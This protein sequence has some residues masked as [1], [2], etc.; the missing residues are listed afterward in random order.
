MNRRLLLAAASL[1]A[2]VALAVPTDVYVWPHLE[3]LPAIQTL[4]LLVVAHNAYRLLTLA[5][6]APALADAPSQRLARPAAYGEL[7][8]TGPAILATLA[9]MTEA[10]WAVPA[11]WVFNVVGAASLLHA[12]YCPSLRTLRITSSS[13]GTVFFIHTISALL[14]THA[15][16]FLVLLRG[17]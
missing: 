12:A 5:Y 11:V 8:V 10:G 1:G 4:T 7:A 14:V 3:A 2:V 9:L 17:L 15:L 6:L 16:I 13:L